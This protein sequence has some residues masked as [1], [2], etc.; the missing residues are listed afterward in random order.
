M[1][2]AGRETH[3]ADSPF[4]GILGIA[5]SSAVTKVGAAVNRWVL[6]SGRSGI[7]S[8]VLNGSGSKVY[9][10]SSGFVQGSDSRGRR[11]PSGESPG[12]R[13]SCCDAVNQGWLVHRGTPVFVGLLRKGRT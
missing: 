1:H 6:L 13:K 8:R 10:T 2:K 5:I 11:Y 12:T 4:L 7:F 9:S 3:V